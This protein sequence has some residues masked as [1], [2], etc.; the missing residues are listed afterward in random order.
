MNLLSVENLSK[1]FGDKVLFDE[2][3]FG[4]A[5]GD[6]TALVAHNG[7]GK[8]T[9]LNIL[10]GSDDADSGEMGV[11]NETSIGFLPQVPIFDEKKT[12]IESIFTT[13]N[14]AVEAVK[15]YEASLKEAESGTMESIE[16]LTEASNTM[17]ELNAWD[18]ETEM[19]IILG[20]LNILH[21]EQPI[22][23]LSG[24][25]RKR[26]AMAKVLLE[27][28]D[29]LILDEPTNHLDVEMIEWLEEYL[30]RSTL[31]LLLVTHDR[32]FLDRICTQIIELED[33]TIFKYEGNYEYYLQKKEER[34][35]IDAINS[36]KAQN[37]MSKE[38]D[39]MRRQ[40]KARST[41]AKYRVEAFYDLKDRAK[42]P[43]TRGDIKL[44][45]NMSRMGSKILE[46]DSVQKSFDELTILENFNYIFKKRERVGIVGKNGVGKSTFLNMIMGL[47]KADSGNITTGETVV[48]GYYSQQGMIIDE[49]KKVIDIITDIS[50]EVVVGKK[51]ETISAMSMLNRFQFPPKSQQTPVH[52]LSGGEK[53]RLYLLTILIK[54]PNFLI[55]D[56]PTNDLDLQTLQT[57]EDFLDEFNGCLMIVTHD[58]YFMDRLA[59]HLFIF[60]G[61]GIVKDFNGKYS[62]YRE[63]KKEGERQA[64]LD[65]KAKKAAVPTPTRT[66][67]KRVLTFKEKQEYEKLESEIEGL[68]TQK[69]ELEAKM[70]SGE[71]DHE[72]LQGWSQDIID[73]MAKLDEKSERWMELAEFV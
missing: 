9:L 50:E 18:F 37:L 48:F 58:R 30:T 43:Q 72:V 22:S 17:E 14:P 68:E 51:G 4:L 2:I 39:W 40:P 20:K 54:N 36:E 60:E 49:S 12:V 66:E 10:T 26:V 62:D 46:L 61:E 31:T 29:L 21:L 19:K 5:K 45:M 15:E 42:K 27:K 25:Q 38:L 52:K 57:L 67:D 71:T 47:E 1:S 16:R 7:A 33:Q 35:Q 53:R 59:D 34:K 41:K 6:K 23:E 63:M 3:S 32:Y 70:I 11:N 64:F 55:L 24:G 8:T 69:A 56:E 28:P 65:K 44:D 73:I 13:D